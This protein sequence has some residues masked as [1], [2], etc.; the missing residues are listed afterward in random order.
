MKTIY[1]YKYM[2]HG[3]KAMV[4]KHDDQERD[5]FTEEHSHVNVTKPAKFR[6]I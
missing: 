3:R 1:K 6:R 5:K 4:A 2:T